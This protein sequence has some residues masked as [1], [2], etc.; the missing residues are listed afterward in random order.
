MRTLQ[1]I[2]ECSKEYLVPTDVAPF[3]HCE[4]HSINIQ[5]RK[6]PKLLGF[7]VIVLGTR[8]RIPRVGFIRFFEGLDPDGGSAA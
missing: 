2:K 7:P 8:V 1:E 5:A 3:L 4:A 6:D